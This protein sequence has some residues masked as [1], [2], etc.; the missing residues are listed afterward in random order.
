ME[1]LTTQ[2]TYAINQATTLRTLNTD[3]PQG[4]LLSKCQEPLYHCSERNQGPSEQTACR[5]I[6][7]HGVSYSE[8]GKT[9]A[10]EKR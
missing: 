9:R 2:L 7:G 8:E 10:S 5:R 1:G 4:H 6:R 3:V